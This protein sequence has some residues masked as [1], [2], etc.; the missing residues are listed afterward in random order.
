MKRKYG[1]FFLGALVF[2]LLAVLVGS[3]VFF[4]AE[5]LRNSD[6]VSVSISQIHNDRAPCNS[7]DGSD[8]CANGFCHLGHCA[9]LVFPA[10]VLFSY[11]I[12]VHDPIDSEIQTALERVLEGPFQPPRTI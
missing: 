6:Q 12:K 5:D 3:S 4:H 11:E 9:K 7:Q 1:R 10:T 2:C 8:P